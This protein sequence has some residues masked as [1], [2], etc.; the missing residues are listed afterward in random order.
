MRERNRQ[1]RERERERER[2]KRERETESEKSRVLRCFP[3]LTRIILNK[4]N[5]VNVKQ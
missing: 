5:S 4:L 3:T 2:R 1:E